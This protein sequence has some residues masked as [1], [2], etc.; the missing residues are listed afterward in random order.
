MLMA[1]SILISG[2]LP[3]FAEVTSLQSDY[4]SYGKGDLIKFSGT[5]VEDSTGL[6]TIVIRDPNDDFVM[7]AQ[8]LMN[9]DNT[10]EKTVDINS[11]FSLVG[12][13]NATA[14]IYNMT[15]GSTINFEY[16]ISKIPHTNE[17]PKTA[18]T[19]HDEVIV[20]EPQGPSIVESSEPVEESYEITNKDVTPTFVDPTKDPQY[21]INR[22][23]NEPAYQEWF[24]K[25]YPHLTIEEAVGY[26]QVVIEKPIVSDEIISE[27]SSEKISDENIEEIM[28]TEILPDAEASTLV[29][30]ASPT[31]NNNSELTQMVLALAGLAV[32]FGAVYGIKRKV[33]NNSEQILQNK[34]TIKKKLLGNIL[35]NDPLDVIRERL[36]KGEINVDEYKKLKNALKRD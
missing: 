4:A 34:V 26:E 2:M 29:K 27:D 30:S 35:H 3:A 12:T 19:Q 10:F 7:L 36:A 13:Y 14:F 33:D 21:Y 31:L 24:D 5:F 28:T 18:E 23:N 22:Y 8:A 11:K 9:P 1:F 20:S 16:G 17:V 6:I 32:L 25:N 15:E